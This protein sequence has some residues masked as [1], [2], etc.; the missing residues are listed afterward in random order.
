MC[1]IYKAIMTPPT[2]ANMPPPTLATAAALWVAVAL[3]EALE[4]LALAEVLEAEEL[5][6]DALEL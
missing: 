3:A 6:L 2:S 5:L 4:L 1:S